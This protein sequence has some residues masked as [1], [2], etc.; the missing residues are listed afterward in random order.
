MWRPFLFIFLFSNTLILFSQ[1]FELE[2]FLKSIKNPV[3]E[4]VM[5]N[6]EKY[7][8]QIIYSRPTYKGFQEYSYRVNENEYFFPAS[9]AKLPLSVLTYHK[10]NQLNDSRIN[11]SN[12]LITHSPFA[13]PSKYVSGDSTSQYYTLKDHI[14]RC[15][16]VSD[17]YS[18]N[19]LYEF[20]GHEYIS[21]TLRQLQF[22]KI[23]IKQRFA[24]VDTLQNRITYPV[25]LLNDSGDTLLKQAGDTAMPTFDSKSELLMGKKY[26][27]AKGKLVRKPMNF[28]LENRISLAQLH[29]LWK[30]ICY[31]KTK[32]KLN[33]STINKLEIKTIASILPN[34]SNYP[35]YYHY[36]DNYRKFLIYGDSGRKIPANVQIANKVGLAYGFASDVAYFK[37][38]LS[39]VEFSLSA[40]IFVNEN[41][42]FN[43]GKYQYENI[44]LPFLGLLGRN[45]VAYE[46]FLQNFRNKSYTHLNAKLKY[47]Y[48][49]KK[50]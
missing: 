38:A 43:D 14:I 22:D 2:K 20:L 12:Q 25:V 46:L 1:D 37:D 13:P 49:M 17:N 19:Y 11:S 8:I 31:P 50:K 42:T 48:S 10:L 18:P 39:N 27:D 47:S 24:H 41:E 23:L 34:Q 32:T 36:A 28:G 5:S 40:V 29:Q 9:L 6:P 7:R 3:F 45:I 35:N 16:V 30:E 15:F 4:K 44:G 26:V 21:S 33:L